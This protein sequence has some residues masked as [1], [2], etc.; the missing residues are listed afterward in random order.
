MALKPRSP[1]QF[2]PAESSSILTKV[3]EIIFEADTR[4]G[5]LFDVVLIWAIL[6]SIVVV[7]L[8]SITEIREIY[9]AEIRILEWGFT[10]LFTVEYILRLISVKRPWL[11]ARSFFGVIDLLAI[12]PT[13]LSLLFPGTQYLI[14]IRS[15]RILRVFRVL[16]LVKYLSEATT[17]WRAINASRL[18]IFVFLYTVVILV[19]IIGSVMYVVEGEESGFTSIPVSIY[20]AIV[21]L[22]TVG[23]GD[24]TPVTPLGQA[25]AAVVMIM[26]YSIIAVPTGIMST[27][28]AIEMSRGQVTTKSCPNCSREGHM[29]DA[30]YCKYCGH[31]L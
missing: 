11:Y 10:I 24:I 25:L 29:P 19:I 9:G 1:R 17:L 4:F 20:W 3:H 30:S 31:G 7:M 6:F 12:I 15:L 22:T 18:K 21:T 13:Y 16:K 26:G 23:F 28:I 27:E 8:E 2:E 14:V 5:K